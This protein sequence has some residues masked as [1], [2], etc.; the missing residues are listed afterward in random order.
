MFAPS[1]DEARRFLVDAWRKY[2]AG[3]PLSALEQT[4]AQ[5]V[6]MHP[7]YHA[8]HRHELRGRLLERR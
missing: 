4:A 2:G 6:A 1:R 7:E 8:V 5:L 3:E